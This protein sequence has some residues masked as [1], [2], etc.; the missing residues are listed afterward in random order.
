MTAESV[1]FI[2]NSLLKSLQDK[3][4]NNGS[5]QPDTNADDGNLMDRGRKAFALF[6][7]DPP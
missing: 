5:R 4:G 7:A 1:N 3:K 6:V 2:L